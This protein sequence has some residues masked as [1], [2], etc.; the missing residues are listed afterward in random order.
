M[1]LKSIHNLKLDRCVLFG[2]NFLGLKPGRQQP[3]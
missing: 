2:G 3:K 1:D